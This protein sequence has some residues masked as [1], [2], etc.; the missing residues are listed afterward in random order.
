[1]KNILY[2]L[3][4]ITIVA[5]CQKES[6][7]GMEIY[8]LTQD[9]DDINISV[10]NQNPDFESGD[11]V[12]FTGNFRQTTTVKIQIVGQ[13]S[14]AIKTIQ[15][16]TDQL[17]ISNTL[18]LGGHTS[19]L[20]FDVEPCIATI[21]FFGSENTITK[22]INIA[23]L[24]TFENSKTI[25]LS[26]NGFEQMGP[27]STVW[28]SYGEI[29]SEMIPA[30]GANSWKVP[31]SQNRPY[32]Y[33]GEDYHPTNTFYNLPED[34]SRV[35]FNIYVYGNG[36]PSSNFFLEFKEADEAHTS[37]QDGK[38]DGVQAFVNLAHTG[39][40]LFSFKYSDLKFSNVTAF[41]G[42]G[43]KVKEPHKIQRTTFNFEGTGH[44]GTFY[45]D[46]PIFTVDG[47]FDPNNF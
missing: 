36:D 33:I 4:L 45:F 15:V 42:S 32:I 43:N 41:G 16:N 46:L 13:N 3:G 34:P 23:S 14:G 47:P 29:T 2:L 9:I 18:W 24:P 27:P 30:Q 6:F 40:K 26:S 21:S 35:W 44:D 12:Y 7:Q 28:P 8:H 31:Y 19:T 17:N 5:A 22:H 10:N 20:G 38:D 1:M 25:P 39:W 37:Y 11:N